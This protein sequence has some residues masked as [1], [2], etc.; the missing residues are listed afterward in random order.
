MLIIAVPYRAT[1]QPE[2]YKQLQLFLKTMTEFLPSVYIFILEQDDNK[3]FNDLN[4]IAQM[5]VFCDSLA[6]IN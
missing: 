6:K 4:P 3:Q 2:R 5:N 1:D